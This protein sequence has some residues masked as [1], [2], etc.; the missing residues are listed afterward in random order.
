MVWLAT[1]FKAISY[2]VT[3]TLDMNMAASFAPPIH[4]PLFMCSRSFSKFTLAF[5]LV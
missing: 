3:P 5:K 1:D 2:Q 4:K